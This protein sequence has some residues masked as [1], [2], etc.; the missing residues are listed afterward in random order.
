MK[1][2]DAIVT[3]AIQE[4][5]NRNYLKAFNLYKTSLEHFMIGLKYEK[6]KTTKENVMTRVKKYI[7]RAEQLKQLMNSENAS[8]KST[9]LDTPPPTNIESLLDEFASL[10]FSI[11]CGTASNAD[12]GRAFAIKEILAQVDKE[13]TNAPPDWDSLPSLTASVW[14]T[15]IPTSKHGLFTKCE[16]LECSSTVQIKIASHPFCARRRPCRLLRKGAKARR[17]MET[18]RAQNVSRTKEPN[19]RTVLG[20][21]G[22]QR[23]GQVS[24]QAIHEKH[25]R[26]EKGGQ[27][28]SKNQVHRIPRCSSDER[29]RTSGLVQHGERDRRRV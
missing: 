16:P 19:K 4:D 10:Q 8:L 13:L 26:W 3:Q 28:Q 20:S 27:N 5:R 22:N 15:D 21:V 11:N 1:D 7:D 29:K 12:V 18:V 23:R 2:A 6:N 25:T 17:S 9:S 14:I 24:G